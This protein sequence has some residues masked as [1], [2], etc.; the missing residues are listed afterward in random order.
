MK[1]AFRIIA[2]LGIVLL[3]FGLQ[4]SLYAQNPPVVTDPPV[5]VTL[6]NKYIQ[7]RIGVRG[8]YEVTDID[9]KKVKYPVA[10]RWGAVALEGD[11]E[12]PDDNNQALIYAGSWPYGTDLAN[13]AAFRIKINNDNPV[14]VG[15]G[16]GAWIKP[17]LLVDA[18][19]LGKGRYGP[20]IEGEWSVTPAGAVAA[21]V[22]VK[23]HISLVRDAVR[24][25]LTILN[26]DNTAKNIGASIF[27]DIYLSG[28]CINNYPFLPGVGLSRMVGR[29]DQHY[30]SNLTGAK[31]PAAID[32]YDNIDDPV[33]VVRN[34]IR[35]HD[36]VVPDYFTIGNYADLTTNVWLPDDYTPNETPI[37]DEMFTLTWKQSGVMPKA[38][39]KV[40]TYFG[41]A[42]ASSAWT[43]RVGARTEQDTAVLAVQ[44]PRSLQY[45]ST[46]SGIPGTEIKYPIRRLSLPGTIETSFDIKAYVYNLDVDPGRY[47]LE[48]V[49][50]YLYLPKGLRLAAD[51]ESAQQDMGFIGMNSEGAPVTWRVEATGT[52]SGDLEYYVSVRDPS[53]WQQ[54][55]SR[56]IMVPATKQ[57]DLRNGYQMLCPPYTAIT[58]TIE[59]MFV[60]WDNVAYF[61][62]YYDPAGYGSYQTVAQLMP[63][64]AFWVTVPSIRPG[65]PRNVMLSPDS[66]II[67]EMNGSQLET[68]FVDLTPGWNMIGIPFLYPM[69]LG[70]LM[71]QNRLTYETAIFDDAVAKNWVTR[72]VFSWNSEKN[73]YD[74]LK[75]SDSYLLPWN[76]YWIRV[77][78]P[79]TLVFRPSIYPASSVMTLPGGF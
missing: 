45:D 57:M 59:H 62:K 56:K 30:G 52:Y 46:I 2:L 15:S 67:G 7:F 79:M 41:M 42:A 49:S 23:A 44:G 10:G 3:L 40:V 1:F 14:I 74:T 68:Q 38:T 69:Y 39:K 64:K 60:G 24:M 5:Y 17:F 78:I 66:S 13:F 22:I 4:C 75:G 61:A 20:Y 25:E 19:V 48:N 50:A 36:C 26:N 33:S 65:I 53:G 16:S 12:T 63:S 54:V 34:T 32:W 51:S 43:R 21:P 11:P 77:R 28:S 55:V 73:V 35:G 72:T 76:G 31:I 27:G 47:D 37:F 71:F 8:M 70:Q 58:P 6:S 9:G 18:P 29:P